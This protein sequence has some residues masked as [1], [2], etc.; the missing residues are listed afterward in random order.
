MEMGFCPRRGDFIFAANSGVNPSASEPLPTAD[1]LRRRRRVGWFR[2]GAVLVG[3][4]PLVLIEVVLRCLEVARPGVDPLAGIG[5][6][7][8]VFERVGERYRT[9]RTKENFFGP[10]EFPVRKATNVFRIFALGGSTVYGHPYL[11]E[12][13]FPKWLEL[14]LAARAPGRKIEAINC[15]GISYASYR[16]SFVLHEVLRYEPDLIVLAMGHNEF[17]EDRTYH[18]IKARSPARRW[19]E[20][21][22]AS[23]LTVQWL[24]QMGE[25]GQ[26]DSARGGETER[27][28]GREVDPRLDHSRAG[29]ASYR[30]DEAWRERVIHQFDETFRTMLVECRAAGVPVIV[31]LLGSNLRDCPPFKSEHRSGLTLE[32]DD[33]WQRCFDEA[34][35]ADHQNDLATAL[36]RYREAE[37]IDT[38][39]ALL[40]YRI[41]RALDRLGQTAEARDY[42]LRAK[43]EDVCPLRMIDSIARAQRRIVEEYQVPLVDAQGLL[44]ERSPGRLPGSDWYLDHVHPTI[45]GHQRIARALAAKVEELNLLPALR[46]ESDEQRRLGRE[47]HLASL[48][49]AYFTNGRRRVDWLENW[50][51]RHKLHAETLPRE[52]FGFLRQG[53]RQFEL[54]EVEKARAS[55]ALALQTDAATAPMLAAHVRELVEQGRLQPEALA[56]LPALDGFRRAVGK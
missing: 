44:E 16:L 40:A 43:D 48:P 47:Q 45:G 19:V 56:Q 49:A 1:P 42:Y 8:P 13:A 14:E 35:Q 39:H 2:F 53:M 41:A 6:Q 36:A 34:T 51:R 54:G 30:R 38:R 15:G 11:N 50:A 29:Y 31:T 21:R 5:G 23:L 12:T 25:I 18:S 52:A 9:A 22:A 7:Q 26:A 46:S 10:Q 37:A 32:Q 28:A 33:R 3:V 20:A 17:L 4:L 24:R 27:S 55:F